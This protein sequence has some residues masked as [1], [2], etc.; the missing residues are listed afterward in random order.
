MSLHPLTAAELDMIRAWRNAPT[1]RQAMYSHH[2][3]TLEE[4]Q[5]WFQQLQT[6]ASRR[7]Y[8]YH[9]S[10]GEP[11]GMVYFTNIEPAQGTALWGFYAKPGAPMGSGFR[12][13]LEALEYAFKE[14]GLHKLN[15]EVLATNS[16]VVNFNKLIG[17][18]E[19]GRLRQ[20]HFDGQRRIDVIQLGML[21]EEWQ[22]HQGGLR[23]RVAEL[24]ALAARRFA[25]P[26]PAGY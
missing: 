10:D 17:F 3:I 2:E 15:G 13:A 14:L 11:Q 9:D 7:W 5:V 18:T 22:H 26:P 23:V 16:L 24:D 19:E 1:V 8:L 4:H 12:M 25:V 6:D 20:Q 21:A